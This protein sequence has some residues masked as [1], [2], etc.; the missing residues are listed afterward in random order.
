[1]SMRRQAAALYSKAKK[2][3]DPEVKRQALLS[4]RTLL[5]ELIEKYPDCSIVEKARQNLKVLDLELGLAPPQ[6][7]P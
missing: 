3:F 1:S 2:T 4:S 5:V 7:A 6:Q